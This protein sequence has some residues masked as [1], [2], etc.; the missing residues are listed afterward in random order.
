MPTLTESVAGLKAKFFIPTV[1]LDGAGAAGVFV[2]G[3]VGVGVVCAGAEG[4]GVFAAELS[5][6]GGVYTGVPL[7]PLVIK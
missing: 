1:M 4:V 2:T 3:G 6:V 7:E 5:V